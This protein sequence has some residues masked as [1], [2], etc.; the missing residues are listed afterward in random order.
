[1][2][3]HSEDGDG[4]GGGDDRS[5][6]EQTPQACTRCGVT[7]ESPLPTW[8]L[9]VGNGIRRYYR[10]ACSRQGP[11]AIEGRLDAQWW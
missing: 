10:E 7:S 6:A 2:T 3:S 9:S 5:A 1:M 11:G 4:G 8:T